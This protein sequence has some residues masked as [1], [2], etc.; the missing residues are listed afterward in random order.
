MALGG[1]TQ[2]RLEYLNLYGTAVT[3]AGIPALAPLESLRSLYLWRTGVTRAGA[4]ALAELLP[5]VTINLGT[6][7]AAIDSLRS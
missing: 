3:D 1:T 5:G 7:A 2:Q 4:D 6:S